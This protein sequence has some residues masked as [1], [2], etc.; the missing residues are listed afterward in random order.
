M[1]TQ[2]HDRWS[3]ERQASFISSPGGRWAQPAPV[4]IPHHTQGGPDIQSW[5]CGGF[6]WVPPIHNPFLRVPWFLLGELSIPQ[7][8]VK[9][10]WQIQGMCSPILLLN[11]SDQAFSLYFDPA[12]IPIVFQK[13]PLL[14][15]SR[16]LWFSTEERK[17]RLSPTW[18]TSE[19]SHLSLAFLHTPCLFFLFPFPRKLPGIGALPR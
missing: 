8:A 7:C 4:R 12:S 1:W 3:R 5:V 17:L 2:L 11:I 16:L 10:W 19:R 15:K 9:M 13:I 18:W 14:Q 6:Q